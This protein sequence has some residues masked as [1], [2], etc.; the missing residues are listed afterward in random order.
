MRWLVLMAAVCG[1]GGC[2]S[3]LQ[4]QGWSPSFR[5]TRDD[6][7]LRDV[8]YGADL[9]FAVAEPAPYHSGTFSQAQAPDAWNTP[10]A[11]QPLTAP[12]DVRPVEEATV[13][14]EPVIVG[15]DDNK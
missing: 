15:D 1:C 8:Y 14:P 7:G 5:W 3:S 4:Y 11:F 10:V 9:N 2:G 12:P 13:S 6:P